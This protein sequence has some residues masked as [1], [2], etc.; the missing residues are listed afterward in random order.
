MAEYELLFDVHA[1]RS[2][3]MRTNAGKLEAHQR[4]DQLANHRD[5]R[6]SRHDTL[7]VWLG[8][9]TGTSDSALLLGAAGDHAP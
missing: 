2:L 3:G 4:L 9:C 7:F 6:T 1:T 8:R 5:R